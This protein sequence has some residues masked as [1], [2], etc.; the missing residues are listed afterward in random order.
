MGGVVT[1]LT[2]KSYLAK[3][4]RCGYQGVGPCQLTWYSYQDAADEIGG[5]WVP[6]YNCRIGFKALGNFVTAYGHRAAFGQYNGGPGWRED[7][8]AVKYADHAMSLLPYWQDVVKE[9]A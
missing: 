8:S 3:R 7:P 4:A 2:Y 1:E 5:C 9:R 6:R